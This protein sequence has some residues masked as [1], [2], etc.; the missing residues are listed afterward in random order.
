VFLLSLLLAACGAH[1]GQFGKD[2]VCGSF[3]GGPTLHA[4][5]V[6]LPDQPVV[7][8]MAALDEHHVV[9]ASWTPP[10]RPRFSLAATGHRITI[11]MHGQ[12]APADTS[13]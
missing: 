12:W 13:R 3:A 11:T 4:A 1:A 2:V 8:A 7:L 9:A 6:Q 5:L 10:D